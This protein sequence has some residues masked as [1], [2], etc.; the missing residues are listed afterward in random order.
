MAIL[1]LQFQKLIILMFHQCI[2]LQQCTGHTFMQD[3][4]HLDALYHTY[5]TTHVVPRQNL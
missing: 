2:I 1:K 3:I 5:I 4:L